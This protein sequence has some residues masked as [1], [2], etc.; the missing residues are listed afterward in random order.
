M[1][2]NNKLKNIFA[3]K[4]TLILRKMIRQPEKNG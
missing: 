2:G 4:G 1:E 3:D